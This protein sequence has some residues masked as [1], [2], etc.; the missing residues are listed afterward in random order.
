MSFQLSGTLFSRNSVELNNLFFCHMCS[1]RLSHFWLW[2]WVLKMKIISLN[3]ETIEFPTFK[4]PCVDPKEKK[5]KHWKG[6]FDWTY[7]PITHFWPGSGEAAGIFSL[8]GD[9]Y[10]ILVE[11]PWLYSGPTCTGKMKVVDFPVRIVKFFKFDLIQAHR[12]LGKW[13]SWISQFEKFSLTCGGGS[14]SLV[15]CNNT[16]AQ[17]A[18]KKE[19]GCC[20]FDIC[21]WHHQQHKCKVILTGRGLK[22]HISVSSF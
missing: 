4:N 12:A 3:F 21:H 14:A 2:L 1:F 15:S 13:R 11:G 10:F 19:E 20:R 7:L 22:V 17:F 5:S 6:V 9:D 16:F 18:R 8:K